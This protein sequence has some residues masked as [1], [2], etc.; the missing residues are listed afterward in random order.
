MK[1]YYKENSKL[2][3]RKAKT[4]FRWG[5]KPYMK[6]LEKGNEN[7]HILF[8]IIVIAF[9]LTMANEF[10]FASERM[11]N[12]DQAIYQYIGHLITEG[13]MPYVDAFDHKGPLLYLIYAAGCLISEKWGAWLINYIFMT[14]IIGVSF[15]IAH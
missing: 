9:V 15:K 5:I 14:A 8:F 6:F 3:Y 13:Q 7:K 12:W 11:Q 10:F 4:S 1:N 2:L